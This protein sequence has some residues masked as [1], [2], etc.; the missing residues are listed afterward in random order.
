MGT[1]TMAKR[2]ETAGIWYRTQAAAQMPTVTRVFFLSDF[3]SRNFATA[4]TT[5]RPQKIYNP[6]PKGTFQMP[7]RAYLKPRSV[8]RSMVLATPVEPLMTRPGA[9]RGIR[10]PKMNRNSS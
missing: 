5:N 1:L 3:F 4:Y 8:D 9:F 7:S 10:L 6:V 2:A